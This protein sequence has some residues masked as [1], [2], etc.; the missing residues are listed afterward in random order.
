MNQDVKVTCHNKPFHT[1]VENVYSDEELELIWKELDYYQSQKDMFFSAD[2]NMSAGAK[3]AGV[4][5]KK[6][7]G[8]FMQEVYSS[9]RHSPL[10]KQL[11]VY[12]DLSCFNRGRVICLTNFIL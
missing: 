2:A 11:V 3:L 6:N 5:L 7:S 4:S 9:A 1:V 12:L 10:I 8:F